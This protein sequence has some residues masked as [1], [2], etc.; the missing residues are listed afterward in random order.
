MSNEAKTKARVLK[1]ITGRIIGERRDAYWMDYSSGKDDIYICIP[2]AE[3]REFFERAKFVAG[4]VPAC[5]VE[6]ETAQ[7]EFMARCDKYL[8]TLPKNR[9]PDAA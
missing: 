7:A 5:T 3:A 4:L 9:E 8:A 1:G 6:D 2:A